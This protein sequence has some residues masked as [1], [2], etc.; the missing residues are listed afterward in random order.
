MPTR[1]LTKLLKSI[2]VHTTKPDKFDRYLADVFLTTS[3]GEIF[4][5]NA[6]LANGHAVRKEVWEFGD[7][8]RGLVT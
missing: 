6:L 4:L 7:W 1:A 8:E 3:Q 2:V 5:N